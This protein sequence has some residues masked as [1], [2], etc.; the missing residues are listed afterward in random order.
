MKRCIALLLALLLLAVAPSGCGQAHPAEIGKPSIVCTIFPQYDWVRQILGDRAGDADLSLLLGS[1]A[2]LHNYQ[3]SVPDI[4]MIA[5]CDLFIYVGGESDSWVEDALAQATNP[6]MIT[7][8]LLHILGDAAKEE[9]LLPGMEEE[10]EEED[11]SFDEHVWLSLKNAQVFCSVIAGALASLDPGNAGEY[12]ANLAAYDAKLS[13]LDARYQAAVDAAPIQ[14]LL[15]GDR[16]PFR[17]LKDDYG[18]ECFAAFPGCSAETEASFD[19]IAGLAKR[20]NELGLH[21]VMVT[22]SADKSI[23][24]T[25]IENTAGKDQ[26]ILVLDAMQSV[27][28]GGAQGGATYLSIME[29]NL[30][31]LKEALR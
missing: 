6:D 7:I 19:T 21:T 22:E 27:T 25:I 14:T 24:E 18:L 2:D 29:G 20:V 15:F 3:P 13:A 1:K 16:F 31:V 30:A 8:N 17:Y 12:Q 26:Q 9:E 5:A 28:A 10:D 4:A 23:A 11:D